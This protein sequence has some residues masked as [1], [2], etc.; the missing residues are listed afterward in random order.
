MQSDERK[1]DARWVQTVDVDCLCLMLSKPVTSSTFIKVGKIVLWQ[2]IGIPMGTNCAPFLANLYCYTYELS[3]VKLLVHSPQART[4]GSR[5]YRWIRGMHETSRYI[6]NLLTLNFPEFRQVMYHRV[7]EID[8]PPGS[9]IVLSGIYPCRFQQLQVDT[10]EV[11]CGCLRK[12][13]LLPVYPMDRVGLPYSQIRQQQKMLLRIDFD[14]KKTTTA[15][16]SVP[17]LTCPSDE[18]GPSP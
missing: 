12:P 16:C 14:F 13:L 2:K 11:V 15:H 9:G 5:K 6:D 1:R 7:D 4:R 17:M 10:D 18:A 8:P 3:F